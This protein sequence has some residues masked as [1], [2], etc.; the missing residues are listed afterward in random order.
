MEVEVEVR[1][2]ET[3][4]MGVVHHSNYLVWFELARTRLCARTGTPYQEIEEQGYFLVVTGVGVRYR[5]SARYPDRLRIRCRLGELSSR[6][7]TFVYEV[8]RGE[9]LLATGETEHLWLE[10]ATGR[11]CRPPENLRQAFLALASEDP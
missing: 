2:A 9:E 5:R 1:Y 3:D 7:L 6:G 8:L 10:R 4:Q 11:P